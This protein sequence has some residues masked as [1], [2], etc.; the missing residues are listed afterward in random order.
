MFITLYIK[1]Y[2]TILGLVTL[3]K[4]ILYRKTT[5][6]NNTTSGQNINQNQNRNKKPQV[7]SARYVHLNYDY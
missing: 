6:G 1:K 7:S 3:K 5:T 2:I 4:E